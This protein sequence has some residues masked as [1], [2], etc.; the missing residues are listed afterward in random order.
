MFC[1]FMHVLVCRCNIIIDLIKMAKIMK[2]KDQLLV[3]KFLAP[4]N[5]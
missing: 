3:A 1:L 2:A 4:S 5:P